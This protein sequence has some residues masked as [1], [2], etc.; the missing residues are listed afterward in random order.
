MIWGT[1]GAIAVRSAMTLVVVWLLMIPGLR[2]L[3]G[4]A[5]V[6]IAYKL[7]VPKDDARRSACQACGQFLGAR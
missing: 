4:L 7:L 6:W 2:F 5:L 1:V 3:G